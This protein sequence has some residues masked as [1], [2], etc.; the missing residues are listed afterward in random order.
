M[1][2]RVTLTLTALQETE[3]R[4]RAKALGFVEVRAHR[5]FDDGRRQV[6]LWE[7]ETEPPVRRTR[8]YSEPAGLLE[9][10]K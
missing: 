9:V 3:A 10:T 7:R 8:V 4:W 2:H 6:E 1:R 5:P